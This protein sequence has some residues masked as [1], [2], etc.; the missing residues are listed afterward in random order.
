MSGIARAMENLLP[1]KYL[2]KIDREL[3]DQKKLRFYDSLVFGGASAALLVTGLYLSS[4]GYWRDALYFFIF[5]VFAAISSIWYFLIYIRSRSK[6][7]MT[8]TFPEQYYRKDFS[9]Y[10]AAAFGEQPKNELPAAVSNTAELVEAPT[11]VTERT[12]KLLSESE[13]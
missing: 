10:G 3:L 11:S 5:A 6:T 4:L 2:T 8:E 13:R 1:Y 7:Q 12:T 9:V